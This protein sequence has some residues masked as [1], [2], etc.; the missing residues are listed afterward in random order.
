MVLEMF[1]GTQGGNQNGEITKEEWVQ[2]SLERIM[3]N[4][5]DDLVCKQIEEFWGVCEDE[6]AAIHRTESMHVVALMRQRLVTLAN[7]SQE[8]YHL[9]NIF[10]TFDTNGNG[11][12]SLDELSGLLCKLG[13]ECQRRELIAVFK[14]VD[15]NNNGAIDFE[16]FYQFMIVDPYK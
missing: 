9:R 6:D 14:L 8:E 2:L 5:N 4:Q 15:L 16:E 7:G 11:V 12:L 1:P 13:V 10:R 3:M